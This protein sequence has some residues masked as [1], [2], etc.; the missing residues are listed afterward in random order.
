[1]VLNIFLDCR[2]K[3]VFLWGVCEQ[4]QVESSRLQ[5]A[6]ETR[7]QLSTWGTPCAY[8]NGNLEFAGIIWSH[9]Y[10][11]RNSYHPYR[12]ICAQLGYHT[13]FF[14]V[15]PYVSLLPGIASG[16]V[17]SAGPSRQ[18]DGRPTCPQETRSH[19]C[20]TGLSKIFLTVCG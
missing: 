2:E 20:P 14:K 13:I 19:L 15:V 4:W 6:E 7:I 3:A 17:G 8:L 5:Q 9:W 10:C 11:R 16:E 1:M 18:E 12:A